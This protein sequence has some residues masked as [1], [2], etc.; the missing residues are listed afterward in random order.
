VSGRLR[1]ISRGIF[2]RSYTRRDAFFFLV[3]FFFLA[4]FFF[5]A[6]VFIFFL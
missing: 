2:S 6:M 1:D 3:A 4:A 5:F